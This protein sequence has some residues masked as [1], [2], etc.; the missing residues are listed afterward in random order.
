MMARGGNPFAA[1]DSQVC[2][3]ILYEI[4]IESY[5]KSV[6]LT[7]KYALVWCFDIFCAIV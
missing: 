1:N 2:L 4:A 7:Q 5:C 3:T 6:K